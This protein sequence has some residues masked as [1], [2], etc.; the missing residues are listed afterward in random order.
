MTRRLL[1]VFGLATFTLVAEPLTRGERDRAMSE[2]HATRKMFLDA[3]DGL[4]KAQWDFKP[5]P[6]VWSIAEVS[7]HI[8]V[9]E[10]SL[11]EFVQKK[12]MT[13]P[14]A[15]EKRGST[16]ANDEVVLKRTADRSE[17]GKA[18]EFLKPTHRW[19]TAEAIATEFK[20]RRA[21]TISYTD[22]TGDD[23]RAH[24]MANPRGEMDAYQF[25]LLIA[26]HTNRHVQQINEVKANPNYPKR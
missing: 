3:I 15:P 13:T 26:A 11:L 25:L 22:T 8:T 17:K 7:E 6:E 19:P 12:L 5:A 20:Q 1:F 9:S 10:G 14:A 18:P 4:S 2:L 21:A 24:F 16:K 23:L